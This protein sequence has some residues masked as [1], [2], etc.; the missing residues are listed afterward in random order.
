MFAEK[1]HK[2]KQKSRMPSRGPGSGGLTKYWSDYAAVVA[3]QGVPPGRVKWYVKW[4]EDFARSLRGRPLHNRTAGEVRTYLENLAR[5][6]AIKPWQVEQARDALWILYRVFLN[7]DWA[8]KIPR[9]LG[10]D[11]RLSAAGSAGAKGRPGK[12]PGG[13]FRD[14]TDPKRKRVFRRTSS[15]CG[16]NCGS[17]TTRSGPRRPTPAGPG[18]FSPFTG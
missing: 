15:G 4:A 6:D 5:Q 9:R 18:G 14:R 2:V 17:G 1:Q 13:S 10:P 8:R 11:Q 7:L 3:R 12:A 16:R